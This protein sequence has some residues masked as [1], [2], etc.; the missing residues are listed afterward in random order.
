MGVKGS[1]SGGQE[2]ASAVL[3]LIQFSHPAHYM[4]AQR[5][6]WYQHGARL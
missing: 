1:S 4:A 3:P 2:E 6:V 5:L